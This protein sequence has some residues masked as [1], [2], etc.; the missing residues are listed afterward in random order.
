MR[1]LKGGVLGTDD[2]PADLVGLIAAVLSPLLAATGF[3]D[4][5]WLFWEVGTCK[6]LAD[7][8]AHR[9]AISAVEVDWIALHALS[10]CVDGTLRASRC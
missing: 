10:L 2:H 3:S 7:F 8:F 4:G 5:R 1:V 6:S 9:V